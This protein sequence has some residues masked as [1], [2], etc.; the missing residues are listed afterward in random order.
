MTGYDPDVAPVPEEWLAIDEAERLYLIEQYHRDARV[1]MPKSNRRTHATIHVIVEN[2]IASDDQTT[3]RTTLSRLMNDGLT[4]HEAIHAIGSVLAE[5]IYHILRGEKT[6][7][8]PH[9]SY[10]MALDQLTAEKWRDG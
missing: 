8:D 2:Q 9:A 6:I 1:P 3:V 4:R 7:P 10:Y 5:H